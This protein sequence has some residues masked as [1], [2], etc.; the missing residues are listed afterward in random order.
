M[1][2]DWAEPLSELL[3]DSLAYQVQQ[4]TNRISRWGAQT[5]RSVSL[6]VSEYLQEESRDVV[7][8]TELKIFND[9]VDRLRNDVDRLQ[10]KIQSSGVKNKK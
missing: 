10:A 3:G 4:A 9:A 6:S 8:E 7:T 1:D 5:A 2:I